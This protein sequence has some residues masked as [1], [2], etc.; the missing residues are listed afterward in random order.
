MSVL[1]LSDWSTDDDDEDDDDD[2]DDDDD[3]E[4]EDDEDEEEESEDEEEEEEA[5]A[6]AAENV[7][8]SDDDSG[9]ED[10]ER[11]AVC[12]S[13]FKGQDVGTPESCDHVFCLECIQEWSRV[14]MPNSFHTQ[15]P[16]FGMA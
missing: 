6:A 12:L 15:D 2:D 1:S 16:K 11:C 13:R 9:D 3:E 4:E 14:R 5:A 7:T 10:A 8:V